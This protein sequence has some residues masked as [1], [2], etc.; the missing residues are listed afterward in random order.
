MPENAYL[1]SELYLRSPERVR[2]SCA[3]RERDGEI[4]LDE[5]LFE[6]LAELELDPVRYG[7]E[8]FDAL[9]PRGSSHYEGF[10]VAM[11]S[12]RQAKKRLRFRLHIAKNVPIEIH[13]LFWELLYDAGEHVT[14]ARS[15]DTAFS[16]YSTVQRPLGQ[17]TTEQSRLLCLISAPSDASRYEMAEIDRDECARRLAEAFAPLAGRMEVDYLEPPVTPGRLREKL[18]A[19]RYHLLHLFGHGALMRR[20][21]SCLV[22]ENDDGAAEFVEESKLAEIF[23]GDRGLRLV[24]LV[25]CHGGAPSSSSDVFSG[26]AGRLVERGVPAVV[27]MRRAVAMTMGYSF[28][29]HLYRELARTGRVDVAVNEARQHLFLETSTGL[30]WSS[31]ML[32]MRLQD[33]L[34]WPLEN[35]DIEV[36]DKESP[37]K[38]VVVEVVEKQPDDGISP[39]RAVVVTVILLTTLALAVSFNIYSEWLMDLL[40]VAIDSGDSLPPSSPPE[41]VLEPIE[42]G[43]IGI[44]AIDKDTLAWSS[45]IARIL[46]RQL[47]EQ[48]PD[49]NPVVAPKAFRSSL[50]DFSDGDLSILSGGDRTPYGFEYIL[51]ATQTYGP[52]PGAIDTFPTVSATCEMILVATRKPEILLNQA[53]NHSGKAVTESGALEQAFGRC[54]EASINDRGASLIPT[55]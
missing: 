12:A 29:G 16:R 45:E 1:D 31:P 7:S 24:A 11:E 17:P 4:A 34:L 9:L 10:R 26:L 37:E 50:G 46:S 44:G 41:I 28:T 42:N 33:G 20:G 51:F 52:H 43:K 18:V 19:G 22:L 49:L 25:A 8:L 39:R 55:H 35:P 5:A 3:G 27:G 32:F 54:I 48:R 2:F 14:I 36:P 6:R 47:G 23:L 13:A 30:D 21:T 38:P 15:P 53:F 40:G